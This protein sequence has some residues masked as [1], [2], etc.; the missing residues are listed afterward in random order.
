M[1][2]FKHYNLPLKLKVIFK[3]IFL[4]PLKSLLSYLNIFLVSFLRKVLIS[5]LKVGIDSLEG[6]GEGEEY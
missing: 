2:R 5:F 1:K 4:M 3:S 6:E